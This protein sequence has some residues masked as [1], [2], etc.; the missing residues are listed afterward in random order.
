LNSNAVKKKNAGIAI[1]KEERGMQ[2]KG[3]KKGEKRSK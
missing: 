1:N 2:N 3:I